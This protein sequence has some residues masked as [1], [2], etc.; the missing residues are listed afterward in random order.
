MKLNLTFLVPLFLIL[1]VAHCVDPDPEVKKNTVDGLGLEAK[2]TLNPKVTSND[3]LDT[4]G[5]T[6]KP[7]R[8]E[9]VKKAEV[10]ND[11][12]KEQNE[13]VDNSKGVPSK[14]LTDKETGN[15]Q[16]GSK[17][18]V[19]VDD[20]EKKGKIDKGSE[21]KNVPK[22]DS[23]SLGR[24]GSFR[25]ELCDSSFKCTIGDGENHGLIACLSVPG[26]ESTEVSLLIQNK[27][28]GLLD[29]DISAPDF[30][31][32]DKS[33]IQI[34]ENDDQKVMVSIGDGKTGKFITLKTGEGSCSLDLMD[35]LTHNP[36]KKSNHT[37]QLTYT[38]L[39][40][41]TPFLG[42]ISLAFVL[43][44]VSVLVCVTYQRRRFL[45]N[46]TKYQ[47]LDAELPVSGGPKID[48]NQKDGWDD[49]WGDD[50]DDV[51]APSTPSMPLTPSISSAGVSSRRVNKDAWK[52]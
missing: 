19:L 34:Q 39:F 7:K 17:D 24:K 26:D 41:R 52:D 15:V 9:P 28:K 29:V 31:R 36:M 43:V 14:L 50:W 1:F 42:L 44:I 22:E 51:E 33:K 21:L 32:L 6:L 35:F 38:N 47:K 3:K 12:Q 10:S 46:G 49:N 40:R 25:G 48:F 2:T 23:L 11:I 16:T 20:A 18:K 37:P 30:V 4:S 5:S 27:G 13:V 8:A 45:N